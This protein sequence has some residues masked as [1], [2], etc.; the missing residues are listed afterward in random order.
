MIPVARQEEPE[1]FNEKVRVPGQKFLRNNS[2]PNS[3]QFQHRNYWTH[4]REDLYRLYQNIC[5]YTG[6]WIPVTSVSV[7][8]FIP[9]SIEPQSAY[10]WDNY[11]LTTDKMNN[12][13]GNN[14]GLID[15]FE[16]KTGWFVLDVPSCY[17]KP[18]TALSGDSKKKVQYTIEIL[19]LNSNERTN[20]RHGIIQDY[21]SNN[22]TFDFLRRRYPYIACELE[23][24]SL[25]EN[26]GDYFKL[27]ISSSQIKP[28][29][30]IRPG[31][32]A[33]RMKNG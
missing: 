12:V 14:T 7:D 15:P 13:K 6:E 2:H 21:I 16:V 32:Y 1:D 30:N 29:A 20:K 18:W 22:I 24:Q 4:I 23:R 28:L 17:I 33:T 26:I 9:K 19:K 8:H 31:V 3:K 10:E 25:R 5:A 11:R 27:T